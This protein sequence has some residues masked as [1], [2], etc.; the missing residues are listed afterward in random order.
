MDG[1]LGA[2]FF[3]GGAIRAFSRRGENQAFFGNR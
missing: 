3:A 2:N 1:L